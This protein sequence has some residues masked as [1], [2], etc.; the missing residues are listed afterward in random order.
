MFV[1]NKTSCLTSYFLGNVCTRCASNCRMA[2]LCSQCYAEK[3]LERLEKNPEETQLMNNLLE[4]LNNN[5]ES[6]DDRDSNQDTEDW[7]HVDLFDITEDDDLDDPADDPD[8]DP[9]GDPLKHLSDREKDVVYDFL[10]ICVLDNP[11][12]HYKVKMLVG[13]IKRISVFKFPAYKHIFQSKYK[14][15]IIENK[16][17][18]TNA[19]GSLIECRYVY[20]KILVNIF[21][22]VFS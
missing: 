7:E 18:P 20:I 22:F 9:D 16:F 17:N 12:S 21:F 10:S 5:N 15:Q 8:D 6:E 13:L 3:I 19:P 2:D 14:F 11:I 1:D 4:T